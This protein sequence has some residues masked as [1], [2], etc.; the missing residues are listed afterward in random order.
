MSSNSV[1]RETRKLGFS[2]LA[3]VAAA[4]PAPP[5]PMTSTRSV[6]GPPVA[7]CSGPHRLR[8]APR[9]GRALALEQL[10]D[11]HA[12]APGG[13]LGDRLGQRGADV[14]HDGRI[15]IGEVEADR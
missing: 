7:S 14:R 15:G 9:T 10:G 8:K 5:P 11:R 1:N 2:R 12:P 3:I 13:R 6:M 4:V